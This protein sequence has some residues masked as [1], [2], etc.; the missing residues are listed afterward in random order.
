MVEL[1]NHRAKVRQGTQEAEGKTHLH[2]ILWSQ[3]RTNDSVEE[4][5]TILS[6]LSKRTTMQ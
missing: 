4:A 3:A 5:R 6:L 2:D 1:T